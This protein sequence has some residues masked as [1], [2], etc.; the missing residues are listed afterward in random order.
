MQ[1]TASAISCARSASRLP[2]GGVGTGYPIATAAAYLP[3]CPQPE[4][5]TAVLSSGIEQDGPTPSGSELP[6]QLQHS[7]AQRAEADT[8]QPPGQP[9]WQSS[10][11]ASW[12]A[13]V[14]AFAA[15][16]ASGW[17]RS[18]SAHRIADTPPSCGY[19]TRRR[20]HER[21]CGERTPQAGQHVRQ[22]F[23]ELLDQELREH[24]ADETNAVRT[25]ILAH[26]FSNVDLIERAR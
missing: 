26:A 2:S 8:C 23:Q 20:Y 11:P 25:L 3:F 19:C 22:F 12:C 9:H 5:R 21:S 6:F 17:L 4:Q 10:S 16:R 13:T 1:R 14:I 7:T 18:P 15:T 24:I